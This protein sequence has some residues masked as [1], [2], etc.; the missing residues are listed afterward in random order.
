MN[1]MDNLHLFRVPDWL[2]HNI[3]QEIW[4]IIFWWK[5]RLE[6]INIHSEMAL[7][8]KKYNIEIKQEYCPF[9][10]SWAKRGN[11]W[12]IWRHHRSLARLK[13]VNSRCGIKLLYTNPFHNKQILYKHITENLGIKCSENMADMEMI[14]LLRTV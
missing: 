14:R 7:T 5:W 6:T 11:E 3:P 9:T 12:Y 2:P 4:V 10:K 8:L 1:S 13:R